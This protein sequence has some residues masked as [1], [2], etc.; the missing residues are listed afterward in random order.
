MRWQIQ[1]I[2]SGFLLLAVCSPDTHAQ[3]GQP[4]PEKFLR[5]FDRDRDGRVSREEFSGPPE[6]FAQFDTN[7]DGFAT[8]D[9]IEAFLDGRISAPQ[10]GQK[11]A[12]NGHLAEWYA[13]LPVIITHAHIWPRAKGR[14]SFDDWNGAVRNA[15]EIMD[16]NGVR[17]A[18]VM[19]TPSPRSKG[20]SS[21]FDGLLRV[22]DDHPDRF[23]IAGG[24]SSLNGMIEGIKPDGLDDSDRQ[25]FIRRA[26]EIVRKGGIGFGET[27]A[28]HFSFFEGHAF[29]ETPPDHPLYLLLADLAAKHGVPLDIH[30]EAVTKRWAVSEEL[31][32]RGR[33]NPTWVDENIAAFER[34]LSHNRKARIIWVHLGMDNTGQRS[35]QLMRRLLNA[36]PNLYVSITGAQRHTDKHRL[37][38]PGIGLDPVWRELIL[39]YPDRFMIGSDVFFQPARPSHKMPDHLEAAVRIVRFPRFLPP[40]IARKVAFENAQLV[41][42]L[43]LIDVD[44]VPL[45]VG[46][47]PSPISKMATVGDFL[48]ETEIRQ[49]VI[50][51]TIEFRSPRNGQTMFVYFAENGAAVV[52]S[53]GGPAVRAMKNWFFKD[54]GILCRTAGPQNRD[55]C[56]KVARGP[57]NGT[58]E[59]VLPTQRYSAR[60]LQGSQLPQ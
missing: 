54:S 19:P 35:P 34:L 32:Q 31:R 7:G 49:T 24:G 5:K 50:G 27:T 48:S 18:V 45:P 28:L 51:N 33:I 10:G 37:F 44:S 20:D 26:E 56:T 29:E 14:N 17:A 57:N 42:D 1:S 53:G 59:F 4:T 55:H 6:G 8:R 36:H 43:K 9:E 13:K 39:E 3:S 25:K 38:V 52:R 16:Q 58:F 46:A 21:F 15:L 40:H 22:A 2:L 41:Y 12:V 11:E 30:M 47:A 60:V 23:R